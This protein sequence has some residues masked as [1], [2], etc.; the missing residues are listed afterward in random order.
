M[1]TPP[2]FVII[3]IGSE[4]VDGKGLDTNSQWISREL[5]ARGFPLERHVTV[6]DRPG[7][8]SR[9]LQRALDDGCSVITG[10]GIGP[11]LD[12]RT[13]Q[14]VAELM[15]LAL[16]E[17]D[18]ARKRLERFYE[19][20]REPIPHQAL[21]Q[22]LIPEGGEALY[23]DWGTATPFLVQRDNQ[24]VISL[25]GVPHEMRAL[26]EHRVFPRLESIYDTDHCH[27]ACELQTFGSYE[28][29]LN[30]MLSDLLVENERITSS[31]LVDDAEILVRWRALQSSAIDEMHSLRQAAEERLGSLVFLKREGDLIALPKTPDPLARELVGQ[32]KQRGQRVAFAES[33]TGG[34]AAKLVTDVAG[35]SEVLEA[36][37][38]TYSNAMKHKVL[39]VGESVFEHEGAVSR[40]CVEAMV[41][42]LETLSGSDFNVAISGIAG[43]EGGSV[44]KP[45]GLVW[46]AIRWKGETLSVACFFRSARER[47]RQRASRAALNLIRLSLLF[48]R[49]PREDEVPYR[50]SSR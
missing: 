35:S 29:K 26:M 16:I 37:V 3:A 48:G 23:N 20:R 31:I 40:A 36:S 43:P 8:F 13:R 42:G 9:S 38:V 45:V 1:S 30:E 19:K 49:L 24:V 10:G 18:R 11:T 44:D 22:N 27:A 32:L 5:I 46:L 39:G 7:E 34:L 12:D 14:D 41:E 25:P 2:P 28:S 17:D 47:V 4:L 6:S 21:Q 33:C 50:Y 15:G